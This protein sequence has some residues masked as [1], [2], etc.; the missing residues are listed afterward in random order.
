MLSNPILGV[1][2]GQFVD[3][4]GAYHSVA[5]HSSAAT[6]THWDSSHSGVLQVLS[7]TGF[8]G[9]TVLIALIGS[10]AIRVLSSRS[11]DPWRLGA[12]TTALAVGVSF[13]T[14]FTDPITAPMVALV[15]GGAVSVPAA[16]AKAT[17]LHRLMAGIALAVGLGLGGTLVAAE[18]VYSEGIY[19]SQTPEERVLRAVEIRPW[20]ADLARRVAYTLTVLADRGQADPELAVR[21][22][23]RTCPRLPGSVE[24]LHVLAEARRVNGDV[25]GALAALVEAESLDP[26]N[27]HTKGLRQALPN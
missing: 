18:W 13:A 6:P 12:V 20:D 14:S 26:F 27:P 24:C 3:S 16:E 21:L 1:G 11:W 15:L 4:I 22:A 17:W 9:L 5:F 25:S 19:R 10:I 2:P 8:V 23:E 7:A